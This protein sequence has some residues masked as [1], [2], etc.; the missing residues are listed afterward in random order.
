MIPA[1][2]QPAPAP[3]KAR[4]AGTSLD[5]WH[6][7]WRRLPP[8]RQDRFATLAPLLSV[9]LFLSAIAWPSPTC[10]TR[11]LS[12]SR[13]P[14]RAMSSTPSSACGCAC[15]NARNSSC[16]G[17]R[18]RQQ[19]DQHRGV[20]VPGRNADQPV[21]RTAGDQLGRR[22]PHRAGQP[23]L[24]QRS[25]GPDAAQGQHAGRLPNRRLL[26]AGAGPAPTGLF[27]PARRGRPLRSTLMLQVPFPDRAGSLLPAPSWASTRSTG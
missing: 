8:S 10:A 15:W 9:L 22:A 27:A 25:A 18:G 14:S 4:P 6:R 16:A 2:D 23:R 19:G 5:W 13:K 17:A 12:A 20:R 3:L 26:R 21:P 11:N 24:A 7:W 1:P